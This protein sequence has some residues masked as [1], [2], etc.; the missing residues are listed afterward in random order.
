M[1]PKHV[2]VSLPKS[3]TLKEVETHASMRYGGTW[4][5]LPEAQHCWKDEENPANFCWALVEGSEINN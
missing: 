3:T 5:T 4:K 1:K 2:V